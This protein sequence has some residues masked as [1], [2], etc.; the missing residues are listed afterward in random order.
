[1]DH[2]RAGRHEVALDEVAD[3]GEMRADENHG[4]AA[5]RSA[6]AAAARLPEPRDPDRERYLAL[7]H[8][9]LAE[10]L[11]SASAEDRARLRAYYLDSLTLA[12][13]A[14]QRGEHEA[15]ASR[16][17]ER[18]RRELRA[19]VERRLLEGRAQQDAGDA[20]PALSAA[21]VALCFE[22]AVEDWPFDL[23]LALDRGAGDEP[24]VP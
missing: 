20:Q 8:A 13:I 17:L 6:R 2:L 12:E 9:A 1:V 14:K 18:C 16:Q 7:L 11:A 5:R 3:F 10:A 24:G 15:T 21:Q 19:F 23:K 22:Y 4:E